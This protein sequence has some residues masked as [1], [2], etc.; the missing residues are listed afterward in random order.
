MKKNG[1]V[2][3][4]SLI[5]TDLYDFAL[6]TKKVISHTDFYSFLLKFF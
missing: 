3:F 5:H 1:R 4:T 2:E 6:L